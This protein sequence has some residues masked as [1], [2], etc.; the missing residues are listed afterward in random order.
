MAGKITE[1]ARLR[2]GKCVLS[3]DTQGPFLDTGRDIQRYG[4]VYISMK[5]LHPLISEYGYLSI[6][7]AESLTEERSKLLE[8]NES[9]ETIADK[10]H[11]LIDTLT[12]YLPKPKTT[13]VEKPVRVERAP[14]DEEIEAW[15]SVHGAEHPVVRKAQT[16]EKGSTE[17]W[18]KLYRDNAAR[19]KPNPSNVPAPKLSKED[20][21]RTDEETSTFELMGTEIDLD[22]VL[23]ENI[24]TILT[25]CEEK[26]DE[27]IEALVT[28]ELQIAKR[29]S[30]Q[31]RKGL[32]DPL[33]YWDED[34]DESIVPSS[35]VP[36][37]T[38]VDDEEE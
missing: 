38:I 26:P 31:P 4:R 33:G 32:L 13:V 27:F 36:D 11:E 1:T 34:E 25:Y 7:E 16:M 10:F 18:N 19:R 29:V 3:G 22:E 24:K 9:L 5:W 20:P 23:S 14:T 12:P 17:E 28:R 30:R 21:P 35:N 6:K 15:I 8:E 37:I 2:P